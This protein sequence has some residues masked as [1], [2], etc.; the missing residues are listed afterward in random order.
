MKS[1]GRGQVGVALLNRPQALNSLNLQMCRSMAETFKD[2]KS[3]VS[4]IFVHGNGE[5]G[6]CAGGDIK[7]LREHILKQSS[8]DY[9]LDFFAYE[10]LN[11][12]QLSTISVPIIGWASGITMG[13]GLG[14][15]QGCSYRVATEKSLFAMPEISIGLYPDVGASRFLNKLPPGVG[16]FLGLTGARLTSSQAHHLGLVDYILPEAKRGHVIDKCIR[17]EWTDSLDDNHSIV[18]SVLSEFALKPEDMTSFESEVE[19]LSVLDDSHSIYDVLTKLENLAQK[20]EW[21]AAN[22]PRVRQGSPVSLHVIWSQ[23]ERCKTLSLR[24]AFI[25]E[26]D[27]SIQ[28]SKHHDFPE[29]VRSALVDKDTPKWQYSIVSE[30]PPTLIQELMRSPFK[31]DDHPF[32]KLLERYSI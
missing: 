18:S 16:L 4:A 19:K 5:K 27:L 25:K 28:F 26:Y 13:G 9:I 1:A 29:G 14:L 30:V 2:W 11:D 24:D 23:L 6:F 32:I 7:I 20:S 31:R 12:Y 10:Y 22:M 21:V 17:A 3:K 15:I 8:F